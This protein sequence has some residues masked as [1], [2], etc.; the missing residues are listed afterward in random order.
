MHVADRQFSL[1]VIEANVEDPYFF[2]A[3]FPTD[4]GYLQNSVLH[5]GQDQ[6]PP[7]VRDVIQLC[8][9]GGRSP[10][11]CLPLYKEGRERKK[12][13]ECGKTTDEQQKQQYER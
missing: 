11:F 1:D 10:G 7:C 3:F 13:L 8:R 6:S 5:T 4:I 12:K 9:R 2:F